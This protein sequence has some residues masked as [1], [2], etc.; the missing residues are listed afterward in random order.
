MAWSISD[1]LDRKD[2]IPLSVA[3]ERNISQLNKKKKLLFVIYMLQS[4]LVSKLGLEHSVSH[5][6]AH[7]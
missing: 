5:D 7:L 6:T 4:Q 3:E 2:G 1:P